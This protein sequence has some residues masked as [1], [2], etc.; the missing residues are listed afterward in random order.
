MDE[1]EVRTLVLK[2]IETLFELQL[3]SVR[4]LL[5]EEDVPRQSTRRKG[6]ARRLSLIYYSWKILT[7]EARP[8]HVN[9]LLTLLQQRCGKVTDRDSLASALAKK[10]RLG[11]LFKQTAPATFA[12]LAPVTESSGDGA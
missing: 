9:E 5:G 8:L 4:L 11:I 6:K 12:A 7:E 2:S 1:Q 3:R 10:A